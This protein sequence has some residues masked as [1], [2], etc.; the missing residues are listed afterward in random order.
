MLDAVSSALIGQALAGRYVVRR[1]IARGGTGRAH[2]AEDR[3]TGRRVA[4]EVL[5][6]ELVADASCMERFRRE[7]HVAAKVACPTLAAVHDVHLDGSTAF[8]VMDLLE[9]PSV[10]DV[11][12][13]EGPLAWPRALRIAIE[14]A[15]ALEHLHRAGLDDRQLEPASVTLVGEGAREQAKLIGLG[16]AQLEACVERSRVAGSDAVQGGGAPADLW[17]LGALLHHMLTGERPV[18]EATLRAPGPDVPAE[19]G[20]LVEALLS[21]APQARP[22]VTEALA[23]LSVLRARRAEALSASAE[24]AAVAPR[25]EDEP[26]VARALRRA[27]LKSTPPARS[28]PLRRPA[29]RVAIGALLACAVAAVLVA[30]ALAGAREPVQVVHT[31]ALASEAAPGFASTLDPAL[32]AC[33]E[34]ASH[35]PGASI[36]SYEIALGPDGAPTELVPRGGDATP[37]E[38]TCI[39]GA[40]RAARWP[41]GSQARETVS[42]LRSTGE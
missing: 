12:A 37:A 32:R 34:P 19:L 30:L 42:L 4:I 35:A 10:A 3:R 39:E 11:L 14:V 7:V 5:P 16:A 36:A 18:G 24:L 26:S 15:E 33:V 17:A 23:R 28:V 21:G 38:R 29:R 8:V 25:R 6:P 13:S 31:G 9:G 27:P 22:T 2:E 20:Q 41:R 1:P 40:L